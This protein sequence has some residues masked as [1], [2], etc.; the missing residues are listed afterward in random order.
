MGVGFAAFVSGEGERFGLAGDWWLPGNDGTVWH[1]D[2][3]GVESTRPD[4]LGTVYM[5]NP[6]DTV[7]IGGRFLP[8]RC[9]VKC[10]P[11]VH[12]DRKKEKGLDGAKLTLLGYVPGPLQ[13]EILIWTAAQWAAYKKAIVEVLW[14]QPYKDDVSIARIMK[15]RHI[16][17]GDAKL[18]ASALQIRYP[19]LR[20]LG[21]STV[22]VE[23]LS[24]P[25]PGPVDGTRVARIR[26]QH[27]MPS[28]RE[29]SAPRRPLEVEVD[30]PVRHQSNP[31]NAGPR[32]PS[33][34][35][36]GLGGP[37]PTPH[38]GTD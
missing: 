4:G 36:T 3:R 31:L 28:K 6:W 5:S 17:K 34:T 14:R 1:R 2:A 24:I 10:E 19:L 15:E 16:S 8:G 13:I 11:L 35:S 32:R 37:P 29:Q 12:F 7:W 18:F 21:V 33:E 30:E 9:S 23:G 38:G 27:Y 26:C 22:V 25:E 20:E